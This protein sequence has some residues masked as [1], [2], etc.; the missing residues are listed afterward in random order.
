MD[1]SKSFGMVWRF[2]PMA[3]SFVREWHSRDLDSK[4]N[5]R[6]R[7]AVDEWLATNHTYHVMR[8]NKHHGTAILGGM[9]GNDSTASIIRCNMLQQLSYL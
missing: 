6:E 5:L 8:D 1:I 3:D 9:F 7:S 2:A 4:L